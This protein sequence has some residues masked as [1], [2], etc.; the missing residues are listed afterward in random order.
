MQSAVKRPIALQLA[1]KPVV[2]R[3]PPEAIAVMF[4]FPIASA[5]LCVLL[6]LSACSRTEQAGQQRAAPASVVTTSVVTSAPWVDAIEALGTTKARESVTL[7]AKITETVRRVNFTDGQRVAAGDVLVELTSGQQVAGLAEAQA[8]YK[9][10]ERLMQRNKDLVRQGTIARQVADTAQA[11]HDSTKARVDVLRAQLSDRVVTAPFSGVLGLR[12][13]S[14]GALVT[15][16]TVITT[17]DDI[18]TIKL[19]FSVPELLIAALE[20]GQEVIAQS[21]AYPGREFKG[22]VLSLDS[23]VD[24]VTRA[25]QV[26]A[27]LPN[28]DHVLR[29]G[30]LLTINVLRAP[31]DALIVPEIAV[32]QV[33]TNSF[34]YIVGADDTVQE[35]KVKLGMR[36]RGVVEV[37][38][39]ISP[40]ARVVIDGT[41]KLRNGSRIT[42]NA[43][44]PSAAS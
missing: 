41:V 16:G 34:V 37:I 42:E 32:V 1:V 40:G 29:P 7:T 11:T 15:P 3:I 27:E 13:V 28:S 24:P 8:T 14:A 31:R 36:R 6:T 35:V 22:T 10:A 43:K 25:V 17:L 30:M 19:D 44:T 5:A 23:R 26:R 4:K 21:A 2:H 33:G 18:D 12:Q 38:E 20:P 9:D 39:G